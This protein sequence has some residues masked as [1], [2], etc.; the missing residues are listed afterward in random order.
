MN[1]Y[2]ELPHEGI[3]FCLTLPGEQ[4]LVAKRQHPF[5]LLLRIIGLAGIWAILIFFGT[6]AYTLINSLPLFFAYALLTTA[7]AMNTAL[8]VAIDW[9]YHI[10]IVTNRKI[11]EVRSRPLFSDK[12]D[13]VILDQ[14]RTTEIDTSMPSP[15]HELV[16]MGDVVLGFD[17]PSHEKPFVLEQIKNPEDTASF[18]SEILEGI[19]KPG[20]VWLSN[21]RPN[22][23]LKTTEDV[24]SSGLVGGK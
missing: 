24:Y 14:V 3:S 6:V 9:Y 17:R 20:S 23:V 1:K 5:T 18:L 2:I 22:E 13:N 12:I 10:Y 8:K 7:I 15:I 4:V 21:K 11:L 19:M 16:D